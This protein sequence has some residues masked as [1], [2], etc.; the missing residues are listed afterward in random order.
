TPPPG[1]G[2]PHEAGRPFPPAP[3]EPHGQATAGQ[4][5]PYAAPP[6]PTYGHGGWA[7]YQQKPPTSGICTASMVV[8]II[9][10]VVTCTIWGAFLGIL[11][12]P[13]GLGLAVAA[14][15]RINRGTAHGSGFATAGLV[16]GIV[17]TVLSAVLVALLVFVLSETASEE[18]P[19][20][21]TVE[22]EYDA[23]MNHSETEFVV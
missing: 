8:G 19:G 15:R 10:V 5:Y 16:L 1:Y 7:H 17:A 13:V 18:G 21:G 20:S 4:P 22:Y 2:Y 14:R 12:G 23:R 11:M 6:M 9:A 3:G